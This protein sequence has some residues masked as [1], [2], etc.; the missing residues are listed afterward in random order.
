[1]NFTGKSLFSWFLE[2]WKAITAKKSSESEHKYIF[3]ESP[4]CFLYIGTEKYKKDEHSTILQGFEVMKVRKWAIVH[5]STTS[6]IYA[7][8]WKGYG[9][10]LL[11]GCS[12]GER[13]CAPTTNYRCPLPPPPPPQC[14]TKSHA[15]C[16]D[17]LISRV[18]KHFAPTGPHKYAYVFF[19]YALKMLILLLLYCLCKWLFPRFHPI[20]TR[21]LTF[22]FG[23]P[24]PTEKEVLFWWS[25]FFWGGGGGRGS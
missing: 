5:R 24:V 25:L 11:R 3:S 16:L 14:L 17:L 20:M 18:C 12:Y 9:W 2:L 8:V 23:Q 15:L 6:P 1:M 7:H 4:N 19:K 22:F 21:W 10:P 13:A